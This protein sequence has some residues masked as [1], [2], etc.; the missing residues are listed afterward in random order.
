MGITA[1]QN[2]VF[3]LFPYCGWHFF[4]NQH[5]ESIEK[6]ELLELI[7]QKQ[8]KTD[9][10]CRNQKSLNLGAFLDTSVNFSY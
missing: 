1:F 9:M 6:H 7:A 3:P 10:P 8:V 4:A 5:T 2:F